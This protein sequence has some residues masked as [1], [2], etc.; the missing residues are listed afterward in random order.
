MLEVSKKGDMADELMF[1]VEGDVCDKLKDEDTP[2][3]PI[4]SA[5]NITSCPIFTVS[6]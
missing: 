1:T 6:K 4:F 2:W 5:L 3:Y